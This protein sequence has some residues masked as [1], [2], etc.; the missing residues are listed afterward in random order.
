MGFKNIII[1]FFIALFLCE[2]LF[3]QQIPLKK[4]STQVYKDIESYSKKRK[5][6]RFMYGMIFKQSAAHS[7]KSK[8]KKKGYKKLIKNPY[9]SFEGR[10]IRHIA[11]ETL[12]PF[13]YS[14]SDT[15]VTPRNSFLI[16]ANKTHIKS[17]NITIRNLLLIHQNQKFDSLLV[18]ESERLVRSR[19]YVQD[20]TFFVKVSS[21]NSDSVDILIRE[22]DKWSL[23]PRFTVSTSRVFVNLKDNNFLGLGHESNLGFAWYNA[24]RDLAY[25]LRYFIPNIRNTYINSTIYFTRDQ[26]KNSI[27]SF[28]IDRP[29]FSPY[30]KWAAGVNFIQSRKD[31][32]RADDPLFTPLKFKYNVQDYW[33]GHAT[34]IFKGNT[35]GNRT[36][37]FIAAARFYRFR[38]LEKPVDLIDTENKFTDETF[39]LANI[40]ISTRKYVQDKFIFKYGI[41]EDVPIG[42]VFSL[43]GGYQ[44]INNTGRLYFGA[45]ISIGNY[46]RWGYLSS[47]YEYGTFIRAS[48]A[49]QG[50]LSA[51]IIYFTGLVELGKWKFRQFV[52]PQIM[53]GINRFSSDS[54]TLND[55]YGMDGFNSPKL[56]GT[57]RLLFTLQTQSYSPW[58]FIGF[59]FGPFLILSL[60]MLGD[61][62]T[63]FRNNK[64][65]SQI[66]LGVLIKN[67]NLV[68][69]T[70]QI[71]IAFY[72]LIPGK[73]QDIF[74]MNSFKTSDFDF[75]DFEIG[76][77][78]VILFK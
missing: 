46:Y 31:S 78:A 32:I 22:L 70:F 66:A 12:D 61:P 24:N 59:H 29:F 37:N 16:N 62:G 69:N 41:T 36:T 23:I 8:G 6:T 30:A 67:E 72:P 48:H 63:G 28:A 17:Q 54:L 2:S 50:A 19:N 3:A 44:E 10:T 55:G 18:K 77:P 26:Y 9:R 39:Y 64:V 42:R 57:S 53:I 15:S 58:R 33:A 45:R 38:Y 21:T 35:D 75:R 1:L 71:S 14:I 52:K 5:F 27:R 47:N 74:K 73:G 4:D 40:G 7:Q 11:I 65:Y 76:K 51:G 68:L 49:E 43:T 20:V 13:G 34:R 60:G 25:N 56:S